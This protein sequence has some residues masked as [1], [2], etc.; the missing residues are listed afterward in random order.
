MIK[1]RIVERIKTHATICSIYSPRY[2]ATIKN[3]DY[4]HSSKQSFT[5][6]TK[7]HFHFEQKFRNVKTHKTSE[8]KKTRA[9]AQ[10]AINWHGSVKK[11]PAQRQVF[12][13]GRARRMKSYDTYCAV[14]WFSCIRSV[15]Y[16]VLVAHRCIRR[17]VANNSCRI[18]DCICFIQTLSKPQDITNA[19][20]LSHLVISIEIYDVNGALLLYSCKRRS[21]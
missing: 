16:S 3:K 4:T 12:I 13:Y 11:R 6:E 7:Q 2:V 14:F 8:E 20:L 19:P 1:T 10:A 21:K 9:N 18:C 15:E 17:R 5:N